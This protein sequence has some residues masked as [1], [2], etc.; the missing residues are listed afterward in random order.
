M[1]KAGSKMDS[2]PLVPQAQ[3]PNQQTGPCYF[4][5]Q[6]SASRKRWFSRRPRTWSFGCVLGVSGR[7]WGEEVGGLGAWAAVPSDGAGEGGW[8]AARSMGRLT[9]TPAGQGG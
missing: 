4:N 6:V 2:T 1:K 9:P 7:Y 8:A 3:L 5:A